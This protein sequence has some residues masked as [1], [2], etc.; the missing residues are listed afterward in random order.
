MMDQ[1]YTG[2]DP[3]TAAINA[4]TTDGKTLSYN[5]FRFID[6]TDDSLSFHLSCDIRVGTWPGCTPTVRRRR[7]A[8]GALI[9]FEIG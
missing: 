9:K 4:S 7:N 6:A 2:T 1:D 3:T 5:Q 8:D